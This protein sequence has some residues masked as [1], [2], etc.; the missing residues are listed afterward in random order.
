MLVFELFVTAVKETVR[1]LRI[2]YLQGPRL[3]MRGLSAIGRFAVYEAGVIGRASSRFLSRPPPHHSHLNP[4]F[5]P[6]PPPSVEFE[7]KVVNRLTAYQAGVI[8]HAHSVLFSRQFEPVGV[9]NSSNGRRLQGALRRLRD[10]HG[11]A[12]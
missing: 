7:S 8:H 12:E 9:L 6:V 2:G 10:F 1:R 3:A 5:L 4:I 11:T